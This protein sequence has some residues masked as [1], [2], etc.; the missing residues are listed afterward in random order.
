MGAGPKGMRLQRFLAEAGVASRRKAEALIR[1]GRVEVNGEVAQIGAVVDPER[2]CVRVDGEAVRRPATRVYLVLNKPRGV[3]CTS[4]DPRGR[5]TVFSLLPRLPVRVHSVGRLDLQSEGV[6]LFTNDGDLGR[7]LMHPSSG[8]QRVYHVKVQGRVSEAMLARL[9]RG[10][11]LEDGPARCAAAKVLR[12]SRPRPEPG[13]PRP[14]P[15]GNTW[16]EVVLTEGRRREVRR[17]FEAVRLTVLKLKRVRF[18]PV[19]LGNLKP[20]HCRPLTEREVEALR[21]CVTVGESRA[22]KTRQR[23][24]RR[25]KS[26]ER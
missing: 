14:G 25:C 21:E 24:G 15:G 13:R 6:L 5:P 17:M 23:A 26:E 22:R 4:S 11:V 7:A 1:Q 18:G 10:V 19:S 9:C 20:G 3:I 2:D 8:V 16:V 12:R